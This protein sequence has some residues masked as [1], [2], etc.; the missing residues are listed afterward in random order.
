MPP[1]L[2]GRS[3][4]ILSRFPS[5]M[6]APAPDKVLASAAGTLG[7]DMDE[8]ERLLMRI[9]RA[10]RLAV[11]EEERDVLALAALCDL[12][13]ADFFILE[14]LRRH[15]YFGALVPAAPSDAPPIT[16]QQREQ[17]AYE[18]FLASLKQSVRRTVGVLLDG[19]GT[20]W[21]LLEGTAILLDADR[22][23]ADGT[24]D[25]TGRT[26]EHLDD[27]LV[28]G[29]FVHRIAVAYRRWDGGKAAEGKGHVY[30]V[31]NPIVDRSTS[32]TGR[33][34]RETFRARRSGFFD[35]P[36]AVVVTGVGR[37]TVKPMVLNESGHQGFVFDGALEPGQ[38]LTYSVDG[39]VLLDSTDVTA[40]TT[41]FEGGLFADVGTPISRFAP[42]SPPPSPGQ[43]A[44]NAAVVATPMD[45]LDRNFPRPTLSPVS[46]LPPLGLRL[47]ES[48]WRFS[49]EEGAFDASAFDGAVFALPPDPVALGALPPSGK[50]QLLWKENE[51]FA[52]SVL[53]PADLASLNEAHVVEGDIP[54]LVRAGLERFRAGGI[55]LDVSYFDDEWI[56]A[57][58]VLRSL[59]AP[60]GPGVSFDATA[61]AGS[62]HAGPSPALAPPLDKE[63][64]R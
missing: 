3:G 40:R 2:A 33:R 46:P 19:C 34:Q 31:E 52:A 48:V 51:P 47:G 61:L 13:A 4:T 16:A 64:S 59:D 38:K 30:L 39:K 32:D 58:S 26:I 6:R 49:V 20:L 21:A 17:A 25:P 56:L 1:L 41:F 36:V 37:R 18:L 10:H 57:K 35:G 12:Q 14:Q 29:G 55:R 15:G 43:V 50:V 7:A 24:P 27:R 5:F 28:H 22:L 9:Q 63:P 11:S 53:I 54:T 45:G 44:D 60:P 23:A 62:T 42:S 8:G